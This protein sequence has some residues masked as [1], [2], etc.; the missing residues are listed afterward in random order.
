[1][2]KPIIATFTGKNEF[3]SNFWPCKVQ[4]Q[5]IVYPSVE[6]GFQACK[7]LSRRDR[8]RISKLKTATAAKRAGRRLK[9]RSDW[10]R[11]KKVIMYNFLRQ[12]FKDPELRDKLIATRDAKLIEGNWWGDSYWGVYGGKGK[13]KL[14]KLLMKIR[15]GL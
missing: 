6:H 10:E 5:G 1:M 3:L 15:D 8:I 2:R 7:S 14:G 12:K 11:V 13:N 4:Y 9:L